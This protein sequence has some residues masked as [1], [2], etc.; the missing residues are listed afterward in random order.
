MWGYG[1]GGGGVEKG[2]KGEGG[3]GEMR[4]RLVC[5]CD[6]GEGG[7]KSQKGTGQEEPKQDEYS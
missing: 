1:W 6:G 3:K 5:V 2:Q 4:T 7:K